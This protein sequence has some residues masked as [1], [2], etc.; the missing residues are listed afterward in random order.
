MRHFTLK[1]LTAVV[2][3]VILALGLALPAGAKTAPV[4]GPGG[5]EWELNDY[6]VVLVHGIGQS[7]VFLYEDDNM[8]K[9]LGADGKPIEGWP[10]VDVNSLI[11]K[12]LFPL[13]ASLLLQSDVFLT[14]TLRDLAQDV[15]SVFAL[16]EEGRP[17]ENM[18]VEKLHYFNGEDEE[19]T[20]LEDLGELKEK[21]YKNLPLQ[22]MSEAVGED[23]IYYFAYNSFGNLEDTTAELYKLINGILDK[24]N[25]DKVNIV[26][27]SLGGVI[28]NSLVER[29]KTDIA[30]KLN[31]V[32]YVI[33]ALDGSNIAGDLI[34]RQL[35]TDN[36]SLYRTMFPG[37][38]DGYVGCLLNI[39]IRLMPKR[40]VMKILDA[41]ID[42]AVGG[43]ISRCTMMWGLVPQG[44]Y[45][46]AVAEWLTDSSM[47]DI[48]RQTDD[49]HRAQV[50][51]RDNI[52]YLKSKGVN[53]YAIAH[54]NF[55]MYNFVASAKSVSADGLL[56]VDSPSMGATS[57]GVNV[58]MPDTYT[59]AAEGKYMDPYNLVDAGTGKLP[60]HTWYFK[61]QDHERTGRNDVVMKLTFRLA[62]GAKKETVHSM[63][64]WPQFNY[65]RDGRW[66]TVHATNWAEDLLADKLDVKY[67]ELSQEDK[68]EFDAAYT[69]VKA[70]KVKTVVKPGSLEEVQ[71]RFNNIMY[72]IGVWNAPQP[73]SAWEKLGDK[74]A[75]FLSEALYFAYGPR[76][77][78]DPFWRIWWD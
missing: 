29:Y 19:P 24:H 50:N 62:C 40:L 66:L 16:D 18:R 21:G 70:E 31:N 27:I 42:G 2:L 8:T 71:E 64:E 25:T 28:M 41:V 76:G 51:A 11:P 53:C 74:A 61:D 14:G 15:L 78:I 37:L 54:Y 48:K 22:E 38:A 33:A 4:Q 7:E 67:S 44:Y 60:D 73:P 12:L 1:R 75:W 30:G 55:P 3:T 63:P 69:D 46:D 9:A 52:L 6:P 57:W 34:T 5:A 45:D 26:P 58:T 47:A 36:E 32:V 56:Q 65:G 35:A 39:V 17:I 23:K 68:D 13:L 77:F 20:S 10:S 49:Y 72:K 59:P 43:V